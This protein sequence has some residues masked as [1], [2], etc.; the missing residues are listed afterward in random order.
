MGE[1]IHPQV[2]HVP[3]IDD[4]LADLARFGAVPLQG[5]IAHA[6]IF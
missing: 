2:K 3:V 1:T 4:T 5:F 6:T